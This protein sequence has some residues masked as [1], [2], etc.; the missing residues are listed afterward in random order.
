MEQNRAKKR[1]GIALRRYMSGKYPCWK[2]T[3]M[4][5]CEAEFLRKFVEHQM[6]AGMTWDNFGEV[7]QVDHVLPLC[8][9]DQTL[10]AECQLCWNWINLRPLGLAENKARNAFVNAL[11]ILE[12]RQTYFTGNEVLD[13]LIERARKLMDEE[14]SKL[15][16]WSTWNNGG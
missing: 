2:Y 16:D 6:D 1:M 3:S 15:V 4:F 8:S 14:N 5:G 9:F 7:W 10:Q 12:H 11:E 13:E